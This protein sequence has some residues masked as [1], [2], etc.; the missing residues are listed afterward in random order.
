MILFTE[1]KIV[2]LYQLKLL[3]TEAMDTLYVFVKY[4]G[5]MRNLKV[6]DYKL[7]QHVSE[8]YTGC[9]VYCLIILFLLNKF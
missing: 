2:Q 1:T 8:S 5:T 3:Y 4:N 7:E 6:Q 9:S